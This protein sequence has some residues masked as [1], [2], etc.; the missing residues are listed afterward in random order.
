MS[1][2]K[3]G[4]LFHK[5]ADEYKRDVDVVG[6]YVRQGAQY[7]HLQTGKPLDEC[8]AFI[9]KNIKADGLFPA[10]DPQVHFHLRE[11]NGDR[12]KRTTTLSRYLGHTLTRNEIIAPTFTTYIS[13][14][15]KKSVIAIYIEGNIEKRKKAKN[16]MFAAKAANDM[17]NF[18]IYKV[19]QTGRKLGNNS[20][21]GAHVAASTPLF[22]KTAHST[23]TSTCRT[24]SGYG[25][26]NNEKFLSGNRHYFNRDVVIN[27]I[28]S[29]IDN[30]NYAELA[31]IIEKYNLAYPTHADVMNCIRYST[32]LYWWNTRW[33]DEIEKLV[34]KLNK[35]QCAA[36]VY[37][38]DFYHLLKHNEGFVRDFLTQLSNKVEGE[39]PD[40]EG[41]LK[42]VPENYLN[43]AHQI[44]FDEAVG[45]KPGDYT[46]IKGTSKIHTL[47]LTAENIADVIY[48]YRDLVKGFWMTDNLPA[49]VA[50]FPSSIRRTALTSDTDS[51]I[52]TV[53]DW[54]IW[55]SGE[56]TFDARSR[57]VYA[58]V[59][60][61]TSATIRHVL[62]TMSAN[63]GIIPEHIFRISMK[64]EFTFDV[65]IPTQLG[66]HYFAAIS[67]QEGQVF[68]ELEFEIKGAQLKSANAPRYVIKDATKMMHEIIETIRAGKKIS[69]R[70]WLN[71]VANIELNIINTIKE[72]GLEY[73]RATSIKSK[74]SYAKGPENSPYANHFLWQE[75][76]APKYGDVP[77]PPYDTYKINV[78]T[79][80]PSKFKVWLDT[81]QDQE[82]AGRIREYLARKGKKHI[83]TFNLPA[84]ALMSGG[85]PKEIADIIDYERIVRDICKIYYILLETLGYYALGKKV[86][87]LVSAE[88]WGTVQKLELSEDDKVF[89]YDPELEEE[90]DEGTEM[91]EA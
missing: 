41:V 88:G 17:A 53:Q 64:S 21:S 51:T 58:A 37:T 80:N 72:G 49:S 24:T 31:T 62:A 66:K 86:N 7:L 28:L 2:D 57:G 70:H 68:D 78:S 26:A 75:I 29:I 39:H 79:N 65:F 15:V 8:A 36:F 81:M 22:N 71:H 47:A 87:R 9:R 74:D 6:H 67:C 3:F 76:F 83:S 59:V 54:M 34:V 38:G 55:Y 44:C 85:I 84:E 11:E 69:L 52:F 48:K 5:K 10:K 32:Q 60:F 82:L 12:T 42:K 25:N 4:K 56:V 27:N 89:E 61:L 16:A 40:P 73:F 91:V 19:E 46:K 23:L 18:A 77:E 43:L 63:Q 50:H 35:E 20:V 90:E 14:L 1:D 45:L 33:M 30:S 13:P